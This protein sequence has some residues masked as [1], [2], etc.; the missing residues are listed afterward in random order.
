MAAFGV[1][2]RR[3]YAASG[4]RVNGDKAPAKGGF[5]WLAR[6]LLTLNSS[7]RLRNPV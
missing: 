6:S 7:N 5:G 1:S 4:R 3:D 2:G